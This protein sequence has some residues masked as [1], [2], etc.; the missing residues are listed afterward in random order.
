M[1]TCLTLVALAFSLPINIESR[2]LRSGPADDPKTYS[3]LSERIATKD[4][5][6]LVSKTID[7][8]FGVS[9][10]TSSYSNAGV[11]IESRQEGNWNDQW[12]VL[13]TKFGASESV[14]NINGEVTKGKAPAKQFINPSLLWFWKVKPKAG[15][16]VTADI[17]AQN[18]IATFKIRYTY[19]G[20]E[21]MT[22]AGRKVTVH[23][24]REKPLSAPD[25]VYTIWW[26]DDQGMG[27]KRY[28]KTT[29]NEYTFDLVSWR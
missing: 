26:Y 5:F 11:P 20:D 21:V 9:Y 7:R 27:V 29:Q 3:I 13:E 22:L 25:A 14:Q 12:N 16:V 4:G 6:T 1:S 17:L 18:T 15:T 28:H 8:S 24:V 23:R 2:T 10:S 19:E